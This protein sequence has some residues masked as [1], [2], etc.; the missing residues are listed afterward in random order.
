MDCWNRKSDE[1][2]Y[3]ATLS[4]GR[5][6][7]L[8][9]YAK[10]GEVCIS[11]ACVSFLRHWGTYRDV[12]DCIRGNLLEKL[13]LDPSTRAR[14]QEHVL[15]SH[16]DRMSHRTSD[17]EE[18][19]IHPAVLK[20]LLHGGLSPTQISQMRNL[21]VLFIGMTARGSWVT[22][23]MEVQGVLDK[24]RCPIVQIIDDDKGVHIVAAINLYE[25]VPEAN[26][27]GL[28]V[29]HELIDRQVGCAIGMATGAT[30]CGVTGSSTIACRWDITGPPA[31]RAAR[32]MQYAM[33]NGIEA[34]IDESVYRDPLAEPRLT[35][36]LI[37]RNTF[38]SIECSMVPAR[39]LPACSDRQQKVA[40][41]VTCKKWQ[42]W[43]GF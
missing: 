20:L 29:C 9:D 26:I 13:K 18:D 1:C 41:S 40:A 16:G 2:E 36:A 24:N 31:V 22:W 27:L 37:C 33:M 17:V 25:S 3:A 12:P 21:C 11:H 42:S 28:D 4:F 23:L 39:R 7:D 8:V 34:A 6:G 38:H 10:A 30:F 35:V 14:V 19:F 43:N 32:L 15:T 5:R